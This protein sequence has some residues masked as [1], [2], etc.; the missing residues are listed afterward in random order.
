MSIFL[1]SLCLT[2]CAA[3]HYDKT[4]D[5]GTLNEAKSLR[6]RGFY[7]EARQQYLRIKTEFPQS[8]L[9]V[10]ASLQNAHSYYEEE[11]FT[12]AASAY[13]EFLKTYPGRPEIP[14]AIY[15]LGMSYAKQMPSTPQ[16]DT[17]VTSQAVD[18]FTRLMIDFPDNSHKDEVNKLIEEAREQLATKIYE[19]GR[20][21]EKNN[22]YPAAAKRYANLIEQ[23]P[24]SSLA[25]EAEARQILCLKKSG[26]SEKASRL[27][28]L[29]E[30]KFP[31]S[32]F[33]SMISP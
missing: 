29:F 33:G 12:A 13:Q 9:Q 31:N 1:L 4:T 25:E 17:R 23:Y 27:R 10:E 2:A 20:F 22:A 30:E 6:E 7:E 28:D 15:F 3:K 26:D 18:T 8:P 11:S 5:V 16:R 24:D 32:K 21:Y 19:I 14:E